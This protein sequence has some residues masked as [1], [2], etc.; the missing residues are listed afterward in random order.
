MKEFDSLPAED[1]R[2][3]LRLFG[4]NGDNMEPEVAE[5]NLFEIVESNPQMFIDRWV[6]NVRRDTE[7]TIERAISMNIIRRNKN[8]YRYGSE[9]I[10]RSIAEAVEFLENPKNQDILISVMQSVKSKTYISPVILD[11][12]AVVADV[13]KTPYVTTDEEEEV[14][15]SRPRRKGD[16]L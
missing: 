13:I 15:K 2:R 8:V 4:H 16:T 7:V 12:E 6:N 5:N 9:V 1:T 14:F 3:C 11:E 10:G